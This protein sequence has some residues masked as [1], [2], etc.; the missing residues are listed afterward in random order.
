M[1]TIM[2]L[3]F[4]IEDYYWIHLIYLNVIKEI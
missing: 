3:L 1:K 2:T 4:H